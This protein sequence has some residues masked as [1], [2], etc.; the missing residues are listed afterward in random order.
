MRRERLL[1][2][3]FIINDVLQ[4]NYQAAPNSCREADLIDESENSPMAISAYT[5][6]SF[7]TQQ[8][9]LC[10]RELIST[11]LLLRGGMCMYADIK[12]QTHNLSPDMG[13]KVRLYSTSVLEG[14][15]KRLL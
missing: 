14:E 2:Y 8:S 13:R 5:A 10:T 15:V 6:S 11:L 9:E 4:V 12:E 7:S 3:P 1:H